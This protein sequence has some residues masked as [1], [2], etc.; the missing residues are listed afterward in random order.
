MHKK[1]FFSDSHHSSHYTDEYD[2][3]TSVNAFMV[4]M[5]PLI[6]RKHIDIQTKR[7]YKR[8][9]QRKKQDAQYVLQVYYTSFQ[10]VELYWQIF[11][12]FS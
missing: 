9:M 8:Y 12:F 1:C 7:L 5:T 11:T 2:P 3:S 10:I 4:A 6:Q